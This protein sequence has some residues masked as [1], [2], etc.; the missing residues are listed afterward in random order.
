MTAGLVAG[1]SFSCL[2][3]AMLGVVVGGGSLIIAHTPDS[4]AME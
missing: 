2:S 4:S 1:I 3:R